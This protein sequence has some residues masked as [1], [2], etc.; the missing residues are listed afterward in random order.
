MLEKLNHFPVNWVDGMKINKSH[1]IGMQDHIS[2][3]V[4]DAMGTQLN[5]LNYGLLPLGNAQESM[6]IS[7]VIDNHKLLRV[8]VEECHAVTPN[9]SR[10]A[11]SANNRHMLNM[12]MPYPEAVYELDSDQDVVLLVNVSVNL[13]DKKPFGNPDPEENP[14][15]YPNV[16]PSFNLNLVPEKN[17]ENNY[18]GYHLTL[19]KIIVNKNETY[20]MTN[21]IP[22]CTSVQSHE[23]LM[24]IHTKIDRFFGQLELFTVQISQ[25]INRRNQSNELALIIQALSEKITMYLG[26]TINSFRWFSQ[27]QPPAYMFDQV[28]SLARMMKNYID[29]KSGAGKEELLNYIAEWCGISQGEFEGTFTDLV[30][31]GYN[32]TQIDKTVEKTLRFMQITNELFST[33]NHLDYI[34]KRKDNGIFVKERLELENMALDSSKRNKTFLED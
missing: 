16:L 30:N 28:I 23:K 13:F 19:G 31:V 25:K 10:I 11:I 5:A 27:Y 21:Y 22:P 12:E 34:G 26:V 20:L 1:F 17:N 33:L 4:R 3:V 24:E 9:G 2:D 15:R 14:P 8:K 32:H 18:G 6:K 7:L 29:S